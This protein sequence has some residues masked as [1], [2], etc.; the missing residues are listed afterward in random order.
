MK[1]LHVLALS[2]CLLSFRVAPAYAQTLSIVSGNSQTLTVGTTSSTPLVVTLCQP[3]QVAC[4]GKTGANIIF[5]VQSLNSEPDTDYASLCSTTTS[6]AGT[7]LTVAIPPE[8]SQ[9]SAY[10]SAGVLPGSYTVTAT[11]QASKSS[12]TFQVT[13]V[14]GP[15]VRISGGGSI[16]AYQGEQLSLSVVLSDAYGNELPGPSPVTYTAPSTEPSGTFG[17]SRTTTVQVASYEAVGVL[18]VDN[19]SGTF[20]VQASAA[21]SG[22]TIDFDITVVPNVNVTINTSP[23]PLA[24]VL[25]GQTYQ[26]PKTLSLAPT[27]QHTLTAPSPQTAA[28]GTWSLVSWSVTVGAGG[29]FYVAS[30]DETITGTFQEV[31][32]AQYLLSASASPSSQG[33]LSVNPPA[34]DGSYSSG[35]YSGHY[36]AGTVVQLTATPAPGYVFLNWGGALS[37]ST[38]PQSVTMNSQ[39]D[40][41]AFFA[42]AI[43]TTIATNPAGLSISVDGQTYTAPQ[44][45]QWTQMSQ[46][47]IGTS[48]PQTGAGGAR[49]TFANWSDGGA[50]SHT[51]SVGAAAS[52]YTA[53]FTQSVSPLTFSCGAA[54]SPQVGTNYS[55][56]CTASGGLSP[57][58]FTVSA[59]ALPP[60][61]NLTSSGAVATVGGSPTAPGT[62]N[63]TLKAA[64][65]STPALT[66]TQSVS[67][68]VTPSPSVLSV[69]PA[70]GLM[71]TAYQGRSN[72]SPQNLS[73]TSTGG[74]TTFTVTNWPSWVQVSPSAGATPAILSVAANTAGLPLGLTS[75]SIAMTP[76]N[77]QPL[78]VNVQINVTAFSIGAAGP[79]N[80][81]V[82]A[83]AAK[84][85]SLAVTTIDNGPASVQAAATTTSGGNWLKLAAATLSAPGALA[86][87]IDATALSA[88][89]YTG[90]ITLSCAAANPCSPV[91]VTV[92]LTVTQS[93]PAVAITQVL[94]ATGEAALIS[95]NTWIEIKG[96]NLSQTTRTW[97]SSDFD[98]TTGLMPTQ[99]DGVSATVNGKSAYVYYISQTQVNVL[100]PLDSAL[101]TVDVQLENSLGTSA[102]ATVVMLPDSLGFFAFNSGKYAAATHV[103]GSLLGPTSLYPGQTTPA[104]AGET[105]VLYG[106][107]FGQTNPP[108]T[109]GLAVQQGVLPANPAVTIG[110]IAANVIYAAVVSPGLYQFNVVVPASAPPG[111]LPLLATYNGVSTQ[112]GV[113]ITVSQ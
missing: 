43:P 27:S 105:I 9:A 7:S 59:G 24:F 68:T 77:A 101:G 47:T 56:T 37:G 70:A 46:H 58:T 89:N 107:G 4:A 86:Y 10:V 95:Q 98:P 69:S 104:K 64:D 13:N 23:T 3:G 53:N 5:Q 93:V 39:T 48:S 66:A 110:G 87:T 74:A 21:C 97:Q 106:N 78:S 29:A 103:D 84:N 14:A 71:F 25:D 61:L 16:Q 8:G 26:S 75:G 91:P 42:P 113:V 38:N 80:E 63:F 34:S 85:D 33:S 52:T 40:L 60:G 111:D 17:G 50:I 109:A 102:V 112:P 82:A 99:L 73:L 6:C 72:P 18:T 19:V 35:T 90:A 30:A 76:A 88:G 55:L 83:G 2:A 1:N 31:G 57:Y 62:Y 92:N 15:P 36:N 79:V 12:V 67:L 20:T 11:D 81:A 41:T 22:C 28:G 96:T 32:P 45:F 51:I 100:T 44:T 94:N 108:I 65:N 49:E 54:G